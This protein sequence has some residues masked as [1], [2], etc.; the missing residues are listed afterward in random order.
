M[1]QTGAGAN[2]AKVFKAHAVPQNL[3][4]NLTNTLKLLANQQK[5]GD[6]PVQSIVKGLCEKKGREGKMEGPGNFTEVDNRIAL[7]VGY[8]KEG[9]RSS[10][11]RRPK[12]N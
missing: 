11:A 10:E 8:L 9:T 6:S 4:Q 7:D 2:Q 12:V 3:C 5:D 1:V